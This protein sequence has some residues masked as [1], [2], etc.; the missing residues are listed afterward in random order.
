M[1]VL[2][3]KL[4]KFRSYRSYRK[5][6]GTWAPIFWNTAFEGSQRQGRGAVAGVSG[7]QGGASQV[8]DERGYAFAEIAARHSEH[9]IWGDPLPWR[10]SVNAS[11][12]F[13]GLKGASGN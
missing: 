10:S 2:A 4:Q 1:A 5:K 8:R 6:N 11:L 3:E 13:G 9:P 12:P 7:R